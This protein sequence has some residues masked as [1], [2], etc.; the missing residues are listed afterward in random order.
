MLS[1]FFPLLFITCFPLVLFSQY[2]QLGI[3]GGLNLSRDKFEIHSGGVPVN[4]NADVAAS[5]HFG[6]FLQFIN[7]DSRTV[8]QMELLYTG[9]GITIKNEEVSDRKRIFLYQITAPMVVKFEAKKELY[10][11]AGGYTGRVLG[12][13]EFTGLGQ[14]KSVKENF[15]VF[16]LGLLIGFEYLVNP[17][18]SFDLRYNYGLVNFNNTE[19]YEEKTAVLYKNRTVNYGM[20][21]KF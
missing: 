3:K 9:N 19:F 8:F 2:S 7:E 4:L 1:K 17:K 20:I 18:L 10:L 21:Y 16:D 14:S 12:A 11:N 5:Y 6:G 15:K 13:Q